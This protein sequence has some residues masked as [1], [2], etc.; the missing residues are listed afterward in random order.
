MGPYKMQNEIK[1]SIKLNVLHWWMASPST[2]QGGE[3]S[4]PGTSSVSVLGLEL[5]LKLDP[6][7]TCQRLVWFRFECLFYCVENDA[8]VA[9]KCPRRRLI[10][11][12]P[13][14]VFSCPIPHPFPFPLPSAQL[15]ELPHLGWPFGRRRGHGS[16]RFLWPLILSKISYAIKFKYTC[17][18]NQI[19]LDI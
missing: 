15:D 9:K 14:K 5:K 8:N 3:V 1:M 18:K 12:G 16:S 6:A 7:S 10:D 19:L 2:G 17:D 13:K 4:S 11:C